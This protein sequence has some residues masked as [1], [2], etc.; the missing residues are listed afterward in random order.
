MLVREVAEIAGIYPADTEK[1]KITNIKIVQL[2]KDGFEKTRS[3]FWFCFEWTLGWLLA[4]YIEY[5][6]IKIIMNHLDQLEMSARNNGHKDSVF[7][8]ARRNFGPKRIVQL[9]QLR[10][11]WFNN[12][13]PLMQHFCKYVANA[14]A[15]D[16]VY[17]ALGSF[18][19][20]G[21]SLY[22]ESAKP[23]SFSDFY[24]D[25]PNGQAVRNRYRQVAR[26]YEQLGGGRT[27]SIACGSAQPLIHAIHALKM[28]GKDDGIKLILTDISEEALA[29][30]KRRA[31]QAM[32]DDKVSYYQVA[33]YNLKRAFPGEKFDIVEACGILDYLSDD[34]AIS[35]LR[36]ALDFLE[37]NGTIIV[38][39]MSET[40]GAN[41]LRKMYNWEIN[42]RSPEEFGQLIQRAGGRNI[43]VYVEPWGIHH[44]AIANQK[45]QT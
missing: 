24:L 10:T 27:L 31:K 32:I 37:D 29:L 15:L 4:Q 33:F 34:H 39:N 21:H 18:S 43:R 14:G 30:A 19:W 25:C 20:N 6:S 12:S 2:D 22:P 11:R 17:N 44:V 38:S 7:T 13:S 45:L 40:R 23:D 41:L 9:F 16:D 28:Q 42:Y 8:K 36:F 3:W 26:M 5:R 1:N 35:L